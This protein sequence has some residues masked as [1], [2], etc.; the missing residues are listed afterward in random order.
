M[1]EQFNPARFAKSYKAGDVVTWGERFG[2]QGDTREYYGSTL[3]LLS[4]HRDAYLSNLG[5]KP[6]L[7]V[8]LYPRIDMGTNAMIFGRDAYPEW[9]G[10]FINDDVVKTARHQLGKN[11]NLIGEASEE[12][13]TLCIWMMLNESI[14]CYTEKVPGWVM[15]D[16]WKNQT[17]TIIGTSTF[18]KKKYYVVELDDKENALPTEKFLGWTNFTSMDDDED[19]KCY[20]RKMIRKKISPDKV[21]NNALLHLWWRAKYFSRCGRGETTKFLATY[22]GIV[23]ANKFKGVEW[24]IKRSVPANESAGA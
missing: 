9:F 24:N 22:K 7:N 14:H 20:L 19:I 1:N 8:D 17:G 6:D 5:I 23:K 10:E 2:R 15:E 16:N 12:D 18:D 13:I 11:Y 21:S 3:P 4:A